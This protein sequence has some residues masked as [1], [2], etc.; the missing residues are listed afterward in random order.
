MVDNKWKF[1]FVVF[2]RYKTTFYGVRDPGLP[3]GV[4]CA[5]LRLAIFGTVQACDGWTDRRTD[6]HTTAAYTA[7]A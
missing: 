5:T 7:L 4:V 6:G 3:Y 2:S 1:Y